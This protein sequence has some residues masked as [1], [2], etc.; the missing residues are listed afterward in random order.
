MITG[1]LGNML[2]RLGRRASVSVEFALV[3]VFVLLPL[4]AGGADMLQ[5]IS[6]QAQ[7]N[8]ALQS[9]YYFALMNPTVASDT[10]NAG[11]VLTLINTTALHPVALGTPNG[12]LSYDCLQ[13]NGTITATTGT[14]TNSTL[15]TFAS[16]QVTSAVN[17][18]LP[19]TI[20]GLPNPFPLSASGTI[21]IQ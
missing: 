10:S 2:R 20:F 4:F 1:G 15:Q 17:L 8:T 18:P 5:I 12:T 6:A 16:Y 9:L 19:L 13:A 7:V 11:K 14:C 3:S 21:Q